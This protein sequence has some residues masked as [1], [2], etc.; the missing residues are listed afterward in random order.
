MPECKFHTFW[1]DVCQCLTGNPQQHA[2]YAKTCGQQEPA[3][4]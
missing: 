3:P 2:E 1:D 4:K